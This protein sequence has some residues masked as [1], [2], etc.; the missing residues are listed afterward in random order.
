MGKLSLVYVAAI[1]MPP[2]AAMAQPARNGNI[3]DGI[4]HQPTRGESSVSG[5][6]AQ[7]LQ[8]L[9]ALLQ[10]KAQQGAPPPAS[11]SNVYG[12]QPGGVVPITP[13]DGHTGSDTTK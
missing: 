2:M 11:G 4:A 12:V 13:T 7:E 8:N 1:L 6:S 5:Q 10:Q 9:N 3:Y